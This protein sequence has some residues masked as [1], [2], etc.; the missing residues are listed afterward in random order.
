MERIPLSLWLQ[1]GGFFLAL[2]GIF[3]GRVGGWLVD[4]FADGHAVFESKGEQRTRIRFWPFV[5]FVVLLGLAYAAAWYGGNALLGW[6]EDSSEA[7]EWRLAASI[8]GAALS[9]IGLFALILVVPGIWILLSTSVTRVG[10]GNAIAGIGLLVAFTGL[11]L[12]VSD[13]FGFGLSRLP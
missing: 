1:L 2:I 13:L 10:R 12:E 11:A 3:G 5:A 9:L 6:A 4:F 7:V 8:T